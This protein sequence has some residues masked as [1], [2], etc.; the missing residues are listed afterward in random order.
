MSVQENSGGQPVVPRPVFDTDE[1]KG[2]ARCVAACPKKCLRLSGR[3]NSRGVSPAEYMGAG[4]TGCGACF[5][6][7]PEPYAIKIEKP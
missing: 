2:C 4:C 3:L 5:Y 1:C 7:C 6:N